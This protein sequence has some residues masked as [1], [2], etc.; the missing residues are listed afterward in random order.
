[1]V[2]YMIL[3][4][5]LSTD[6]GRKFSTDEISPNLYFGLRLMNQFCYGVSK[7]KT[8][9]NQDLQYF[10]WDLIKASPFRSSKL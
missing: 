2:A 1:M 10:H 4:G 9:Q 8:R 5:Q 3:L 6:I 7:S